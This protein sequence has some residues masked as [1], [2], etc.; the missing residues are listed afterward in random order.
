MSDAALVIGSGPSGVACAAALLDRGI[1]VLMIDA[2]LQLE[3]ERQAIKERL[4]RLA[5]IHWND[6]DLAVVRGGIEADRTG[7]PLKYSFGSDFPYKRAAEFFPT[8]LKQCFAMGSLSRGGLS[9]VWGAAVLPYCDIDLAGA[10]PLT[11]S[12]LAPHYQAITALIPVSAQH[13]RLAAVFPL[14]GAGADGCLPA[15]PMNADFLSRLELNAERLEAAGIFFG[16]AR[17]AVRSNPGLDGSA[18]CNLCRLCLYGCP[19][20]CI[21]NAEQS[22]VKLKKNRLFRYASGLVAHEFKERNDS[23]EVS[24]FRLDSSQPAVEVVRGRRVFLACGPLHTTRI[25]L[26]SCGQY[27]QT[28]RMLDSRY[29][30]FPL[31]RLNAVQ[32][33]LGAP[34]NT[35]SQ[36]FIEMLPGMS[37][38]RSIHL[39]VYGFNELYRSALQKFFGPLSA[40][41]SRILLT[42]MLLV[43]AFMHSDD[44][45]ALMLQL[46]RNASDNAPVLECTAG[47]EPPHSRAVVAELMSRL[48]RN[49]RSIGAFPMSVF[50]R[51]ALPGRG[52]HS[53]GSFPMGG[54][55]RFA[56]DLLG[57][58]L[59]LRRVHAVDTTVFPSIPASTITFSAMANAHRIGAEAGADW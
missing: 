49:V 5:P 28:I 53:G 22:L 52:F 12:R 58:P 24:C 14:H 21:Y 18:G 36:V 46:H 39:Q 16:R 33:S 11:A 3:P 25:L 55:G 9:A 38:R 56:S 44:S 41:V 31:L 57:R 47:P 29:M 42:R 7:V 32:E 17:T 45:P 8:A 1:E 30:L 37:T 23:V 50:S 27:D 43:Q 51:P 59:A 13:D 10:W 34:A 6:A 2:G 48:R 35:L 26:H 15:D 20:D 19:Y 40:A 54:G 4:R